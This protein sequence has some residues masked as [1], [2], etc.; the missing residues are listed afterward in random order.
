MM[1]VCIGD[2]TAVLTVTVTLHFTAD[3]HWEMMV[4]IGNFFLKYGQEV[5]NLQLGAVSKLKK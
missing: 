1:Q 4:I 3:S 2:L 5:V